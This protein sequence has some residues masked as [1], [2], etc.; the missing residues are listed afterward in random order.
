ML[1]HDMFGHDVGV[2]SHLL[3]AKTNIFLILEHY[4][5][6]PIKMLQRI[7]ANMTMKDV[8]AKGCHSSHVDIQS[9]QFLWYIIYTTTQKAIL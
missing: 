6:K 9:R 3:I 5:G 7:K 4:I 8:E 1:Q 2:R